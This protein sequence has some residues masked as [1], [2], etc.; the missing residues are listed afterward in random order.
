MSTKTSLA[1]PEHLPDFRSP[2]LNEVVIGLQ[3]SVPQG[4]SQIHAG[5]VRALFKNDYPGIQEQPALQPTFE[6]FAGGFQHVFRPPINFFNGC[7]HD[8][9]W[10]L[11]KDESEL[12]QFQQDR[13]LHNW[14]KI[15]DKENDYPRFEC[16]ISKF[17]TELDKF[18]EYL[19]K[20]ASQKLT[21]NQC[22][23]SY[24]NHIPFNR[25]AG[26]R[27]SDWL[28]FTSFPED[29]PDDLNMAFR[30]VMRSEDGSPLGR[31]YGEC[32]TGLLPDGKEI[33]ILTLTVKGAPQGTDI[34]SGIDFLRLGRDEIV[35]QFANL[36]TEDAH[37]KWERIK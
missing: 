36:T 29:D 33:I 23:I 6:T 4:Y 22:E 24:I 31:F 2:P 13:L 19:A 35:T 1:R 5:E 7:S 14:R 11:S 34:S 17:A 32:N 9:F 10:F 30:K 3:F 16:M 25:I 37:G 26:E 12:I 8:R 20:L 15:G 27:F 28:R 21:I 18:E